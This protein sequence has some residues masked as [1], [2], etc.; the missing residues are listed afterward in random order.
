MSLC[1]RGVS[2]R[3]GAPGDSRPCPG[4]GGGAAAAASPK[5][6]PWGGSRTV[7]RMWDARWGW[8]GKH[9]R[10]APPESVGQGR[11]PRALHR[12]LLFPVPRGQ[13]G[14]CGA[15]TR[16]VPL[17]VSD[18]V[19]CSRGLWACNGL[20][21]L[22]AWVMRGSCRLVGVSPFCQSSAVFPGPGP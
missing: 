9:L 4:R 7:P 6:G 11:A 1:H 16:P 17:V 3:L 2:N 21:G 14:P 20:C 19:T 12:W 5:A 22:C 18:P 8:G 10:F 13:T 15:E